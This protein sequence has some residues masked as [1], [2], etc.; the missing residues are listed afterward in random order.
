MLLRLL[1]LM[2]LSLLS[3]LSTA[4]SNSVARANEG[5]KPGTGFTI[6]QLPNERK[7]GVFLPHD[8]TPNK[9][10]P[11]IVFLHG[12]FENGSDPEKAFNVGIGPVI[13][14]H[15]STFQ[16]IVIF[17]QARGSWRDGPEETNDAYAALQEVRKNYRV[18]DSRIILTGLSWGGYGVWALA[19]EHPTDFC[20]LVPMCATE[21][22][23]A[24]PTIK[25]IPVWCFHNTLDPFVSAGDSKNMV[26]LINEAGGQAKLTTYT[27]FGHDV[28]VR[29]Y[30]EPGLWE[31]MMKQRKAGTVTPAAG[32]RAAPARMPQ[33]APAKTASTVTREQLLGTSIPW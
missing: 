12:G 33:G 15:A 19:E 2:F 24:V 14:D 16:Y 28:W 3:L 21:K 23:D 30:N 18:D 7:Y 22:P 26:K 6:H 5:A 13:A 31:W 32:S 20:A 25:N 11:T 1:P 29:A 10:Y 27:A 9:W 4:C 17:P 8:Y